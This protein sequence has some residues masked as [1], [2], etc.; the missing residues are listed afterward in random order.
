M[1]VEKSIKHILKYS[2]T[3]DNYSLSIMFLRILNMFEMKKRGN[4]LQSFQKLLEINIHPDPKERLS[5]D[6][7]HDYIINHLNN[8]KHEKSVFKIIANQIKDNKQKFKKQLTK[9]INQDK[10][11]SIKMSALK[12]KAKTI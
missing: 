4:F 2:D 1:G 3:W 5:L 12:E 7:S 6:K 11:M 8:N 10:S 9:Q